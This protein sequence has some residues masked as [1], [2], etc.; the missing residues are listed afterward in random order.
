MG[1]PH[2]GYWYRPLPKRYPSI[3]SSFLKIYVSAYPLNI[4]SLPITLNV[5][6]ERCLK[7]LDIVGRDMHWVTIPVTHQ[8]PGVIGSQ[9]SEKDT[10]TH[11]HT[12]TNNECGIS[13]R[14]VF[15]L[16]LSVSHPNLDRRKKKE[17]R[18]TQFI[19][20][21]LFITKAHT[22]T[23]QRKNYTLDACFPCL[24]NTIAFIL[25][26]FFLVILYTSSACG[27]S[28]FVF[29]CCWDR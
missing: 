25:L 20:L 8:K 28:L 7:Q 6:E 10:L 4:L 26:F 15:N 24:H 19:T 9:E 29:P 13:Q 21:I 23:I 3:I 18:S 17:A 1:S 16:F 11:T 5:C 2:F 27:P 12:H 14:S 22:R